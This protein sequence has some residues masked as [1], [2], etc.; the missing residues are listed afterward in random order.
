MRITQED[1]YALRVVLYLY[2]YGMGK[3]IEAKAISSHENVPPRFLLK[4][5]RKL[6]AAGIIESYKGYGG[7]YAITK[8]PETVS[9]LD[10]LEAVEGPVVINKCLADESACN[11]GRAKTCQM[12]RALNSV[13][14]KLIDELASINFGKLLNSKF[15]A[16]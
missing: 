9:I 15:D 10:V 13:Q 14:Q 2:R 6:A 8:P 3:R 4:L 11:A 1:D 12:H 5:L 16:G 7:G